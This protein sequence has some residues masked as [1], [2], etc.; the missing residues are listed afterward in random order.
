MAGDQSDQCRRRVG[1]DQSGD[2][3]QA[4]DLDVFEVR[5]RRVAVDTDV[6]DVST[7]ADQLYG[8][9]EGLRSAYGLHRHVG[10][11]TAGE[12]SDDGLR[13]LTTIVD[14]DVGAELRSTIDAQ[15]VFLDVID[16]ELRPQLAEASQLTESL[17]LYDSWYHVELDWWT[18]HFETIDGIPQSSLVSAAESD[19]VDVGRTF[20][21]IR[22]TERR[23]GVPED[24]ATVLVV[25]TDDD[26]RSD[27]F[28]SGEV[29][30]AVL[31]ERTLAGMATCTLTH[32]IELSSSRRLVGVL[33]GREAIPQLLIRVGEAPVIDEIPPMT[34]GARLAMF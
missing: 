4:L 34:R 5:C 33:T 3:G 25:S 19:R 10:A 12:F 2:D 9:L 17:R 11:Q 21:V 23:A 22:H 14:H 28:R 18:G 7:G 15:D 24:D 20:P 27:A 8:Q 29:L 13:I 16:D 6:G 32:L 31:L 26:T 1:I 30:S